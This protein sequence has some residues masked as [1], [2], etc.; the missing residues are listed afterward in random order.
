MA[1]PSRAAVGSHQNR[2]D[3]SVSCPKRWTR[4]CDSCAELTHFIATPV[5]LWFC[6]FLISQLIFPSIAFLRA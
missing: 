5:G 4:A 3:A 6:S 2:E 1:A